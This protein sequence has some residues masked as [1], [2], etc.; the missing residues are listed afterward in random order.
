MKFF[1][2]AIVLVAVLACAGF[3]YWYFIV[4]KG[5]EKEEKEQKEALLFDETEKDVVKITIN[6]ENEPE[7]V[8]ERVIEEEENDYRWVITTPVTTR[9][10]RNVIDAILATIKGGKREEVVW[11]TLEKEE[12]YRL[13]RPRHSLRFY[14]EGDSTEYGIDFGKENLDRTKVFAKVVGNEKIFSIPIGFRAEVIKS[15][16]DLR[17]KMLAYFKAEDVVKISFLSSG[18]AFVLEREGEEWYLM[19]ERVKA[20]SIRVEIYTGNLSYGHFVEVTEEKGH[21]LEKYGL[22]TPHLIVNFK[23]RDGSNYMFLVG[24]SLTS[25]SSDYYYA[26]R[27]TDGMVFQVKQDL[28][29]GLLKT[30]FEM[31]DR[32]IFDFQDSEVTALTMKALTSTGRGSEKSGTEFHMVREEDEWRFE[33]SGEKI[34]REYKVDSILRGIKNAEYE[35]I[36]PVKR[37]EGSWEKS[38]IE[39]PRYEVS[40]TFNSG[41]PKLTVQLTEADEET[42][43]LWLTP[44]NGDT[45]YYT[46]GYFMSNFPRERE[47][48]LEWEQ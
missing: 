32:R 27:S 37:G 35:I 34:E 44:D 14:Y 17:D 25:G 8:I 5:K 20:S 15:L 45:V 3:A 22:D 2:K 47:D 12:E 1:R 21:D 36:E 28:V 40:F 43:M 33:D 31:R 38:G 41:R 16:F 9:G 13:D 48:L 10:D 39:T 30:A 42:S 29:S 46:S 24:D 18:G 4:K 23:L 26:T 19:P 11:D 6:E 7:I